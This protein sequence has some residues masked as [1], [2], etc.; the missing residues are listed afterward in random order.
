[1]ERTVSGPVTGVDLTDVAPLLC[2]WM[3]DPWGRLRPPIS[4]AALQLSAEL[5]AGCQSLNITPWFRAGWRDVTVQVDGELTPLEREWRSVAAKLQRSLVRAAISGVNPLQQIVGALK[6]REAAST[7]KA[8]VMI[9]RAG[10]GRY[11]VAICFMGT[12]TRF[13]DWFSNFRI[14]TPEGIHEG[15]SQLT[16]Q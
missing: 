15:F 6:E 3:A 11:I 7:G 4:V 1:M 10:N 9:R 16:D 14:S 12:G 5:A 13:Y 2:P 8:V